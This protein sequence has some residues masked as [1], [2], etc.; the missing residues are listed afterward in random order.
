[1]SF[2]KDFVKPMPSHTS[3]ADSM[4]EVFLKGGLTAR[5]PAYQV[6]QFLETNWDIL[7]SRVVKRKCRP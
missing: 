7:E 6:E 3:C 5:M 1:M 4:C 2:T